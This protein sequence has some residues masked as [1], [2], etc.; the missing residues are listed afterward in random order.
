ML[1]DVHEYLMYETKYNI[2]TTINVHDWYAVCV[3]QMLSWFVYES[4]FRQ[5]KKLRDYEKDALIG[6]RMVDFEY[7]AQE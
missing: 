6:I 2:S 4:T 1:K 3:P 5:N 7:F